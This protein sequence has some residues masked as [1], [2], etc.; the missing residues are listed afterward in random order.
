VRTA[1]IKRFVADQRG[2]RVAH[3]LRRRDGGAIR[4]PRITKNHPIPPESPN[5]RFQPRSPLSNPCPPPTI[6]E[7]PE[8]CG[9]CRGRE[10]QNAPPTHPPTTESRSPRVSF[11]GRAHMSILRPLVSQPRI[12][13][14]GARFLSRTTCV[15]DSDPAT[16]REGNP[17]SPRARRDSR[18]SSQSAPRPQRSDRQE[19]H[20]RV[21]HA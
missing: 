9:A 4:R 7:K 15:Q 20:L 18:T 14:A 6:L 11:T 5:P 16:W 2:R 12:R 17:D 19:S 10:T 1:A 13:H 8:T 21:A 3:P